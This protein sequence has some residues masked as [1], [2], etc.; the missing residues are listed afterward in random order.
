M[1]IDLRGQLQSALG[2]AYTLE[3]E[4]GGGGMSRVF[5]A[6]EAALGRRVVVKVLAPE[7][8]HELSAERFAREIRLAASLQHANIVPVLTAG[9]A[10]NVPYYTMPLV[11][12]RSLRERLTEARGQLPLSESIGIVRDVAR[13][14]DYAHTRGVVHRDIKPENVLLSGGAAVVTDFGIAKAVSASRTAAGATL[15]SAGTALGT[16]AY[17]APEQVA[18]DEVDA[19]A[20]L[21]AWGV[22]AYELLAGAHP[23]AGKGSS[24]QLLAAHLAESAAPLSQH[25]PRV[26][27]ALALLVMRCLAK[28]AADR[29]Q[30]ARE[31]MDVLD[32]VSVTPGTG[33]PTRAANSRAATRW[34][35]GGVLGALALGLLV[36]LVRPRAGSDAPHT[37]QATAAAPPVASLQSVAVLPLANVGGD[38]STEYFADGMTDEL[39]SVIARIP[40]LRTVSRTSAFVFKGRKDLDVREIGRRLGVATVL[41]GSV[42]RAGERLRVSAQLTNVADGLTLWSDAYEGT[43][44][45]VFRV[46]DTVARSVAGAL[47]IRLTG[48][49][50]RALVAA[51]TSNLEA[52]EIF[53]HARALMNK[54]TEENL[55][56]SIVLYGQALELDPGY[57]RA[58][59]GMAW[60]MELMGD[61]YLSPREAYSRAREEAQRAIA[62]DSTVDEAWVALGGA[63][64]FLDWD[65]ARAG[66]T[67]ERLVSR[68]PTSTV[69]LLLDGCYLT[70]TGQT[71]SALVVLRRSYDLD[72]FD[73]V[74]NIWP[75]AYLLIE[76]GH[77]DE[78]V[79]R[80]EHTA[81]VV[82]NDPNLVG[83]L[84]RAHFARGE[85]AEAG[86]VLRNGGFA[87]SA[88]AAELEARLG[89]RDE[90][91]R[92][93][94]EIE[95]LARSRYVNPTDV[96]RVYLALGDR[97]QSIRALQASVAARG[98]SP[99]G[100]GESMWD[101][102]RDDPRFQALMD[103]VGIPPAA[104]RFSKA[105]TG[106]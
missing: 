63:E 4:L 5:V 83:W 23:F 7:L 85:L 25:A 15:T 67:A 68:A 71:D 10:E 40:G 60:S 19:R 34:M 20:D 45:D 55:R 82:G 76:T 13:A 57:A 75:L 8:A 58:R 97:E 3:R 54:L 94:R 98:S 78:A 12:G 91:L 59:A 89:H 32:G 47:R 36:M 31:L 80:L 43:T 46:Q 14:L 38:S 52:Y 90:A 61:I 77:A 11:E 93:V 2:A 16:P 28:S 106:S 104:R 99:L 64:L 72:P 62:M 29:P 102:I 49:G 95:A 37:P 70:F 88:L 35:I 79:R 1:T 56:R 105:V 24:Q 92:R 50:Q 74:S 30:S 66:R 81:T 96:A 51:G 86:K 69:A 101:P 26:P 33:V 21:Y 41:E 100:F 87:N 103:S 44:R 22:M 42:R 73:V 18:G 65:F 17:M 9:V 27:D 6:E 84:A 53:L 48:S 39:T